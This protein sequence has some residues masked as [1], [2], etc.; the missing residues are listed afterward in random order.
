[1]LVIEEEEEEEEE[2]FGYFKTASKS[3]NVMHSTNAWSSSKEKSWR[4]EYNG[5]WG[6]VGVEQRWIRCCSCF[7]FLSFRF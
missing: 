5:V 7:M 2:A 3:Q 6:V 4:L 1:L